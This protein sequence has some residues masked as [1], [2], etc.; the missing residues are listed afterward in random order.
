MILILFLINL[1]IINTPNTVAEYTN[2]FVF[3]LAIQPNITPY[4][5]WNDENTTSIKLSLF[6]LII[7]YFHLLFNLFATLSIK[8]FNKLTI[9]IAI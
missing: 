1:D 6:L 8:L 3:K 7:F 5:T 9:V 4:S 2:I